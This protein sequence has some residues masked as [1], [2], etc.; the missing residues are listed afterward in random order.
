[1][2][3]ESI[4]L[5]PEVQHDNTSN[6]GTISQEWGYSRDAHLVWTISQFRSPDTAS[7]PSFHLT[8][9]WEN[10]GSLDLEFLKFNVTLS[11]G[12]N[13][14]R[15]WAHW[16]ERANED[17]NIPRPEQYAKVGPGASSDMTRINRD[18][19][20]PT[21]AR[22]HLPTHSSFVTKIAVYNDGA[23]GAPIEAHTYFRVIE[24]DRL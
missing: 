19:D 6:S 23:D 10:Q 18:F 12:T 4:D 5:V 9:E 7:P 21:D 16:G 11:V 8:T 22:P 14:N 24:Q 13:Q 3:L 20:I 17:G 1:M 15:G 2:H